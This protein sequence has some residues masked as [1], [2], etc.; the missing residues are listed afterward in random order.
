MP[1]ISRTSCGKKFWASECTGKIFSQKPD[2]WWVGM[3]NRFRCMSRPGLPRIN[4]VHFWRAGGC[5][6]GS[7]PVQRPP[8][9]ASQGMKTAPSSSPAPTAP[10]RVSFN[11][12][13]RLH[14][15]R[16]GQSRTKRVLSDRH[17][18]ELQALQRSSQGPGPSR[19]TASLTFSFMSAAGCC[20]FPNRIGVPN[21]WFTVSCEQS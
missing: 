20:P 5:A 4:L 14:S 12:P 19:W 21:T 10:E 11:V 17:N 16:E 2:S 1:P 9:G 6:G 15:F 18:W 7:I 13:M 3:Q 8:R